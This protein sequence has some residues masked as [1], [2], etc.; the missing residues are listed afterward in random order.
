M[1][2]LPDLI[3]PL[4]LDAGGK[5]RYGRVFIVSAYGGITDLLLEHK[6]SGEPGVY[7]LF[8]GGENA[9][10]WQDRLSDVGNRMRAI[11]TD[12]FAERPHMLRSAN[13]FVDERVADA[14]QCLNDVK[15]I[16]TF[17]PFALDA[18]LD[19]VRE[20]LCSMGEAHSARSA[21]MILQ[22]RAVNATFVDLTGWRDNREF[23]L[24]GRIRSGLANIDCTAE[25]P[26]VTGYAQC[27]GG[28]VK[29][30]SR[31]YTEITMSR[32]AVLTSPDEVVIHKEFHLSSA[33]PKIVGDASSVPIGRTNYDIADQ[34]ANL[35][36][37]AIHPSA[38]NM[39]RRRGIPLR[40]RHAFEPEHD[41][42]LID[43]DYR[44]AQPRVEIIA[45]RSGL[46]AF[47]VFDQDMIGHQQD[48]EIKIIEYLKKF[49]IRAIGKDMNANSIT[50]YVDCSLKTMKRLIKELSA[51]FPNAVIESKKVA[52]VCAIGTDMDLPG[53]LARCASALGAENIPI[54]SAS[55]PLRG[56]DV[57][58]V[59][60]QN[61][62]H[63]AVTALHCADSRTAAGGSRSM[64]VASFLACLGVFVL[65]GVASHRHASADR[66][67]YLL[68]D[69]NV[70]PWL[71]GLSAIATNNSGYMFIGVIG[72]T[73][74]TG[75]PAIWLMLGWILGDALAS[76]LVHRRLREASVAQSG[77]TFPAALANWHGTRMARV[78]RLAGLVTVVFLGTYAAAQLTAGS[79]ALT[80]LFGWPAYAGAAIGALIVVVYCLAG[81]IRASI[82][83]DAAQSIV[84]L[85]AMV[86]MMTAAVGALGG[87]GEA[88][89]ALHA[90][91]PQF[92]QLIPQGLSLGP[93]GGPLLFI[94]GWLFAGFSV[95]GQPHIMIR[96]MAL[97][98]PEHMNRARLYYYLW[99]IAFYFVA[100]AVAL[101]SRVLLPD[102]AGFDPELALP[103]MAITLLPPVLV[104]VVL[105]GIFAA[106]MS[107]A[108]SLI[109]S[110]AGSLSEDVIKLPHKLWIAKL[111]TIIVCALALVLALA[112]D[113]NVFQLVVSSWAVLAAAFG[114]L[115]TINALGYKPAES[116]ALLMIIC[117]V[118]AVY[119]WLQFDILSPYYEGAAAI[120]AGFAVFGIGKLLGMAPSDCRAEPVTAGS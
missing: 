24:D 58:F 88:W 48:F 57:R 41:G 113:K 38:A 44:S 31:G 60:A 5:P 25:L 16:C 7:A 20:L 105:A 73:Y 102:T 11:N 29:K 43:C 68:A 82:W 17:G 106:T 71:V 74:V 12:L 78:Q 77:D 94:V 89:S 96:F 104:G 50:N 115:I 93:T 109:L 34:L 23:R 72:Y 87:V 61:D 119:L 22:E 13:R 35:G 118:S 46:M 1:A 9:D 54:L 62:Y 40:V 2:R 114:P 67:N 30:Y 49:G 56:V 55:Q 108:D 111:N 107:T 103:T 33:D 99:F 52:F 81:G 53:I 26:V 91:S 39:L 110:C 83:T 59:V 100:N 112:S 45:G 21:A 64:M 4:F 32:V 90:V 36:M 70:S 117:G 3:E 14:R 6:H 116:L 66:R 69:Q 15:R 98:R 75:L 101:L 51:A 76:Q 47:D 85:A 37:E 80:V 95:V 18:Y 86:L 8:S 79:K 27:E 19:R 92:M 10:E 63:A 65:I 42:T 84:M 97:D 120:L 28:L